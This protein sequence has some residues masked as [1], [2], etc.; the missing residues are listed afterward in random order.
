MNFFGLYRQEKVRDFIFSN[1]F[2]NFSQKKIPSSDFC[3][4][5]TKKLLHG[6]IELRKKDRWIRAWHARI[7]LRYYKKWAW[8]V[9][10]LLTQLFSS[11]INKSAVTKHYDI[12]HKWLTKSSN[13]DNSIRKKTKIL[14]LFSIQ[15]S[16]D[17]YHKQ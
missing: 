13:Y 12:K 15:P 11:K 7:T 9:T 8:V 2:K 4:F 6:C 17:L 1:F 3:F 14:I 5:H 10:S 16:L